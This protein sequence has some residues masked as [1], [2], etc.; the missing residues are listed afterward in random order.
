MGEPLVIYIKRIKLSLKKLQYILKTM[1]SN[2]I[3]LLE[4]YRKYSISWILYD[5]A[6]QFQ[7]TKCRCRLLIAILS[8]RRDVESII[9]LSSL[10]SFH[11]MEKRLKRFSRI[12]YRYA[13]YIPHSKVGRG[14]LDPSVKTF[15]C[16]YKTSVAHFPPNFEDIVY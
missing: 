9:Y 7:V 12:I 15:R 10:T 16:H 1:N 3:L 11:K 4:A 6:V 13:R 2:T 8:K 14:H 5:I